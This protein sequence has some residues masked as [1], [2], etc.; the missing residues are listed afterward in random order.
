MV[1]STVRSPLKH[2]ISYIHGETHLVPEMLNFV[3]DFPVH[4]DVL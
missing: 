2:H 3:F 1:S 4:V